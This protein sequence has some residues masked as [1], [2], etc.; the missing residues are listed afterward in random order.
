MDWCLTWF[1]IINDSEDYRSIQR[2]FPE[3]EYLEIRQNY[4][5]WNFISKPFPVQSDSSY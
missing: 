3:S 5:G 2:R 4:I 1:L